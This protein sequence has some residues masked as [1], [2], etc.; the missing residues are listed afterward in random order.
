[1]LQIEEW[2]RRPQRKIE[3]RVV[4][5]TKA[6]AP[7]VHKTEEK[8]AQVPK[9]PAVFDEE[10][11]TVSTL[12]E[13]AEKPNTAPVLTEMPE[14]PKESEAGEEPAVEVP[15]QKAL[16]ETGEPD[17]FEPEDTVLL[18]DSVA[19]ADEI[20]QI[21][22]RIG[23][24]VSDMLDIEKEDIL[25][26]QIDEFRE[27]AKQLQQLM[28][29]RESKAKEL[30]NVVDEKE[31]QAS[32]LDDLISV[33]QGEADKIMGDVAEK[34]DTMS[35][36]VRQEMSGL[37]HTVSK[38]VSGLTQNLTH[39][40]TQSTEKTRQVVETATQNMI[41][42]NT[43]SL[44]GLKEQLE[45]LGH[46]EQIGELSTEMNS[47]II[48]LKSDIVE[49]IHS[50]DVKCYRNIQASMEEQSKLLSEGDEKT[51]QYVQEQMDD[52]ALRMRGQEKLLKVSLGFAVLNFLGIIGILACIILL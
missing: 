14:E 1:M 22:E 35:S 11:K 20:D 48:T 21:T 7:A 12:A 37:S 41:D 29:S 43:R 49:K 47:Q 46:L 19:E 52:M 6:A 50:E 16:D 18:Q 24:D 30:Q 8:H 3:K 25:I 10:R 31:A 17:I 26:Q 42:Q 28:L 27:K 44:E 23:L 33:R 4:P 34:I 5:V 39:E 38:E 32:E 15:A 40:I 45:Q 13:T 36:D 9:E 51:R 2:F